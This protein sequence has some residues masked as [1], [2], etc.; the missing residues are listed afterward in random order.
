M[1]EPLWDDKGIG[2]LYNDTSIP[3]LTKL[4]RMRNAYEAR[5]AD[6]KSEFD[7]RI[8]EA[9]TKRLAEA[10]VWTPLPDGIYR[11]GF[12]SVESNGEDM[13][14]FV[15]DD[16]GYATETLPPDIRLCQRTPGTSVGE[17]SCQKNG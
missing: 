14:V 16:Y 1:N 17:E 8:I 15:D 9:Y 3:F 10:S 5:I 7:A 11:D 4:Y 13:G 6:L 2:E 12:I